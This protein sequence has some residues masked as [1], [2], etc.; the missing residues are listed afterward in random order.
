MQEPQEAAQEGR[1]PLPNLLL[2]MTGMA[3]LALLYVGTT[4]SSSAA[5]SKAPSVAQMLA[6]RQANVEQLA[7]GTATPAAAAAGGAAAAEAATGKKE[8]IAAISTGKEVQKSVIE[9]FEDKPTKANSHYVE[10]YNDKEVHLG[11]I[12][13]LIAVPALFYFTFKTQEKINAR[14]GR[15]VVDT[16]AVRARAS[17]AIANMKSRK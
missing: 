3:L 7:N 11:V 6:M 14:G 2:A 8:G 9:A 5:A 10:G 13:I 17:Q 15:S 1:K 16:D 12:F 4:G